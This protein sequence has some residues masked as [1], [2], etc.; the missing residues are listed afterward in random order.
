[1]N[2][3]TE[4]IETTPNLKLVRDGQGRSWICDTSAQDEGDLRS[5]GCTLADEITYDRNFGG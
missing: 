2:T 5:Q 1:M 3:T 4:I